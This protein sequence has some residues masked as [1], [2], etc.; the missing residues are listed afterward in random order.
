MLVEELFQEAKPRRTNTRSFTP[1]QWAGQAGRFLEDA[2]RKFTAENEKIRGFKT[3]LRFYEIAGTNNLRVYIDRAA[4]DGLEAMVD[5]PVLKD[6]IA[7]RRGGSGER[8]FRE[9]SLKVAALVVKHLGAPKSIEVARKQKFDSFD[10]M[11]A[12]NFELE[13]GRRVDFNFVYK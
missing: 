1:G 3:S 12:E 5:D 2:L 11:T 6:K 13:D 4:D 10:D 8:K 9:A 7:K